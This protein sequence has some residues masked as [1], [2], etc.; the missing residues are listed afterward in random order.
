ML[1]NFREDPKTRDEFLRLIKSWGG[2][3]F[4]P[5]SCCLGLPPTYMN[6]LPCYL[7][8]CVSVFV[9]VCACVCFHLIKGRGGC[10]LCYCA[11]RI[12]WTVTS[13]I[14]VRGHW[15]T[16]CL[17]LDDRTDFE[18]FC[19]VCVCSSFKYQSQASRKNGRTVYGENSLPVKVTGPF[20]SSGYSL[21]QVNNTKT[22]AN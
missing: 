2:W 12:K 7:R 11:H 16:H 3:S 5:S 1:G 13:V 22:K 21:T 6:Q 19:V 20:N 17:L 18:L 10:F 8:V 14:L 9:Q 4:S 15:F